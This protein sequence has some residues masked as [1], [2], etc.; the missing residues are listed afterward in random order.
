MK[1]DV[2][3]GILLVNTIPHAVVG[4]SGK[5]MLTPLGG[6]DSSPAV[7]LAWAGLNLTGGLAALATGRWRA[8][9]QQTAERRLWVLQAGVF[10]F[11]AFGTVFDWIAGRRRRIALATA[12]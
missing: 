12:G 9:D 4:L 5:T 6:Q 3:A 1:R 11:A 7:N 8:T 10:A 2:A